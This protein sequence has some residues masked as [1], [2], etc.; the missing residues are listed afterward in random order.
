[1]RKIMFSILLLSLI[2]G[3]FV[4]IFSSVSAS[5]EL[6]EDSWNIKTPMSNY[7]WGKPSG[8]VVFDSKVYVIGGGDLHGDTTNPGYVECYDPK[9]DTWTALTPMPTPRDG[10]SIVVYQNK[11]YCIGGYIPNVGS[12]PM[13]RY[14][15]VVEVYDPKTDSWSKKTSVPIEIGMPMQACVVG[16]QLFVIGLNG[17]LCL[18]NHSVDSWSCKASLLV[19]IP[20]KQ[21]VPNKQGYV[22]NGQLFVIVQK[23]HRMEM[24][25]YDPDVDLWSKKAN[26][27]LDTTYSYVTLVRDKTVVIDDKLVIPELNWVY[28]SLAPLNPGISAVNSDISDCVITK[29][30]IGAQWKLWIYD[31]NTDMWGEGKTSPMFAKSGVQLF[32]ITSGVY[33]PAKIYVFGYEQLD[34]DTLQTITWIYDPAN[35]VWSTAKAIPTDGLVA[36]Q[37]LDKLVI[38]DDTF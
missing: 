25:M 9:T 16:E 13:G 17:E 28:Q 36:V 11:F 8:V 33:A 22:V 31:P 20:S 30:V 5:T 24:Y 38:V 32:G 27:P 12:V 14:V 29:E 26:P 15:D 2:C 35:N 37:K 4:S 21:V 34:T 1:M 6:V 3:P 7:P 19:E 23:G 10:V 18:Y